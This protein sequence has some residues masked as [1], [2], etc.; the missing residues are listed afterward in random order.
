[1]NRSMGSVVVAIWVVT[2]IPAL[3][4]WLH[5]PTPGM[6]RTPDGKPN[7]SAPAP[8][9]ADGKPDL[10]GLWRHSN[11]KLESD[12][13]PDDVQPWAQAAAKRSAENLRTDFWTTRCLPPGPLFGLLDLSKI[14]Q[15]PGLI[16]ILAEAANRYRQIF[17]D[18]RGLPKDPNPAWQGYSVGHW[19]GDALV[20][21]TA[22]FNDKSVVDYELHPHTEALRLTER[23]RRRDFGHMERQ[24]TIDDPKAFTRAWTMK[25][26]IQLEPDTELLEFVCNENEK[27]V[28]H[29]V[30]TEHDTKEMHL[31]STLLSKY[32]GEYE[33]LRPGR[34]PL[35]ITVTVVGDHLMIERPGMGKMSMS[36]RSETTFSV[37]F[38]EVVEFVNDSHGAVSHLIMDVAGDEQKAVRKNA[39]TAAPLADK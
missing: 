18:G 33:V 27:D 11:S 21:E 2:P 15:T 10:T 8:K 17:I 3:G 31:D 12:L 28:K 30:I 37:S 19:E 14:V 23:Y 29:F 36:A 24:I 9:T 26:A 4:Q 39:A 16:V 20:V 34:E 25:T 5:Y 22:G 1:M 6:P 13:R 32:A 35:A 7:L 38:G